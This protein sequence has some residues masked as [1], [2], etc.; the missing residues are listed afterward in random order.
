MGCCIEEDTHHKLNLSTVAGKPLPFTG[1]FKIQISINGKEMV[2]KF[3]ITDDMA[4]DALIG[5]NVIRAE[6][7]N[8]DAGSNT[9]HFSSSK[10][11]QNS[12][13]TAQVVARKQTLIQPMV[14]QL[15]KCALLQD[16]KDGNHTFIGPNTPFLATVRGV[17]L[18]ATTD[19]EGYVSLYINNPSL[20]ELQIK[21]NELL[22]NA[23]EFDQEEL[24]E[25][26]QARVAEI[27]TKASRFPELLKDNTSRTTS[28]LTAAKK[29]MIEQAV[30][31]IPNIIFRGKLRKILQ[32]N[33]QVISEDNL[34]L[35]RS[36]TVQH[37]IHL[38]STEPVYTK[39][40]HLPTNHLELVSKW[41]RDWIKI[42]IV[43]PTR[44]PYNS[45]IFCVPKPKGDGLRVVLDYR[46][47]NASTIPDRY[48]IRGVDECIQLV[49]EA[50]SR[51]FTTLDLTT[52]FWQMQLREQARH[53]TAFTLPGIG[54]FEWV[55]SPMGLTGCPASF[56]RLMD[57]TMEG[58]PNVITYIDDILVHSPTEDKHETHV[59]NTLRRL[60]QHN[61]KINLSKCIF[62]A[63]EVA[64]LGHTLTAKGV[65]PGRDK[66]KVMQECKQPNDSHTVRAFL[67]LANYFRSY[68]P[69]F[70]TLAAPLHKLT[71]K[72]TAWVNG[73]LPEDALEAFLTIRK[74]LVSEPI[75]AYPNRVGK[76][77]L[78]C[79]AASGPH[80]NKP[81]SKSTSEGGLGAC[82]MQE[83]PDINS[84]KVIG[85][86][87]R[88][89]SDSENNYS[90]F[91]LEM[92]AA[93]YGIDFY[94]HYL[95]PNTFTLYSDHK[96]LEKLNTQQ[97]RTFNLLQEKML[98]YHFDQK[99]IKGGANKVADFL[100]RMYRLEAVESELIADTR[101]FYQNF[102]K[103]EIIKL[104]AKDT[105][106]ST[107][108]REL[109]KQFGMQEF[110]PNH[111]GKLFHMYKNMLVRTLS[112]HK[113]IKNTEVSVIVAP[114][115][116]TS[117]IIQRAHDGALAGHRGVQPTLN[118][119]TEVFWWPNMDADVKTYIA[120]CKV[121]LRC[122]SKNTQAKV[123]LQQ[124]P[125]PHRPNDR[126]HVDLFGPVKATAQ[127]H[128]GSTVKKYICVMTDAFTKVVR[129]KI[130]PDKT[131]NTVAKVITEEWLNIYGVPRL[132]ITDQGL[133]FNNKVLQNIFDTWGII[134][135][136]TAPYHPQSNSQVEIFNK[137]MAQY[138]NKMLLETEQKSTEWEQFVLP[139]MF[140]YNT[141]LHSAINMSPHTAMFG[142]SAREPLWP[143]LKDLLEDDV[144][145]PGQNLLAKHARAQEF[146]RKQ[147]HTNNQQ[148]REKQLRQY[149]ARHNTS[150]PQ[151]LPGQQVLVRT[152]IQTQGNPKFEPKW[153]LAE[154]IRQKTSVTFL[155]RI[156][157]RRRK[158]TAVLNAKD[159][160]PAQKESKETEWDDSIF[161]SSPAQSSD[162]EPESGGEE[163]SE[164][165][166]SCNEDDHLPQLEEDDDPQT[167]QF[168][169][170]PENVET[171]N[172]ANDLLRFT[173]AIKANYTPDKI[174]SEP[175]VSELQRVHFPSHDVWKMVS[176]IN[177]P[178]RA[179]QESGMT[180]KR[181]I[182]LLTQGDEYGNKYYISGFTNPTLEQ[183]NVREQQPIQQP[184]PAQLPIPKRKVQPTKEQRVQR[185]M[186]RL[187]STNPPGRLELNTP[188]IVNTRIKGLRQR[189]MRKGFENIKANIVDVLSPPKLDQWSSRDTLALQRE[190]QKA[191]LDP[192][193]PGLTRNSKRMSI[194]QPT[195]NQPPAS[196][197]T[198]NPF[199]VL[200]KVPKANSKHGQS[201]GVAVKSF[202]AYSLTQ[203]SNSVNISAIASSDQTQTDKII[204]TTENSS[205]TTAKQI[206][207]GGTSKLTTATKTSIRRYKRT[208]DLAP[209]TST[210]TGLTMGPLQGLLLFTS[211]FSCVG[212]HVAA[213]TPPY[214]ASYG[215]NV[216]FEAIGVMA[217][218]LSNA[219]LS[220]DLDL[221]T[222]YHLA[223]EFLN[224]DPV[225]DLHDISDGAQTARIQQATV[226]HLQQRVAEAFHADIENQ[227][228]TAKRHR[229][230]NTWGIGDVLQRLNEQGEIHKAWECRQLNERLE[231]RKASYKPDP[232]PKTPQLSFWQQ[233]QLQN[234]LQYQGTNWNYNFQW[235]QSLEQRHNH[236]EAYLQDQ[237]TRMNNQHREDLLLQ[238][239][240]S[241]KPN[242]RRKRFV[243]PVVAV[244]AVANTLFGWHTAAQLGKLSDKVDGI[245]TATE[246]IIQ[247][248]PG[249]QTTLTNHA[250]AINAL[251]T[252]LSDTQLYINT[253]IQN[254]HR[255]SLR[256]A[257]FT[258]TTTVLRETIQVITNLRAGIMDTRILP[259]GK[260]TAGLFQLQGKLQQYGIKMLV[261]SVEQALQCP[262]SFTPTE[263]GYRVV[264]T[265]PAAQQGEMFNLYRLHQVP[266][267]L[268]DNT[269][270]T[271][272]TTEDV[273]AISP[274]KHRY[275]EMS[276][277]EL[278]SCPK[279][280]KI[281]LCATANI[282]ID[283]REVEDASEHGCAYNLYHLNKKAIRNSCTLT[284]V[285]LKTAAFQLSQTE[286]V[287]TSPSADAATLECIG[288]EGKSDTFIIPLQTITRVNLTPGCTAKVKGL[289]MT[290]ALDLKTEIPNV[291]YTQSGL[292]GKLHLPETTFNM[293]ALL[294]NAPAPLTTTMDTLKIQLPE[295]T[296]GQQPWW[297]FLVGP[298]VTIIIM[299]ATG[300]ALFCY[301]NKRASIRTTTTRG[302]Q[303]QMELE[304]LHHVQPTA[305]AYT[306]RV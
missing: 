213:H 233:T 1:V 281:A 258:E 14:A 185:E 180:I 190:R 9:F 35:G 237:G 170:Y 12:W 265:I 150:L 31:K 25:L 125:T 29:D 300:T 115:S 160:K 79:D 106:A 91:L 149:E 82:L 305:P 177:T 224:N 4:G 83:Q 39:Q 60:T 132:L 124:L 294:I 244:L 278:A 120:K 130:I 145:I 243:L 287:I 155:V 169:G 88:K 63:E 48:S 241:T 105:F 96:P 58:L 85:Y 168:H 10:P 225:P 172:F 43:Q 270:A 152:H 229:R 171:L 197:D 257:I 87:S 162:S 77:H 264:L 109:R 18:A 196:P 253:A 217:P 282:Y 159:I 195:Q 219:Y 227:T 113:I 72:N 34:D 290:A 17:P 19:G 295:R 272:T 8:Y 203:Y 288:E 277:S 221:T 11:A 211:I 260:I 256:T 22:G 104:Q 15:V 119:I 110:T 276:L 234:T 154:I 38:S 248:M 200:L 226:L 42:G 297:P 210:S 53:L 141:T 13:H 267:L 50:G 296:Q 52:G 222:P 108:I 78:F 64:Y 302:K 189:S 193:L 76:F 286:F 231:A 191:G 178:Y 176:A 81:N 49:G 54:Q 69:N 148:A 274:D 61:L 198:D 140:S 245:I 303:P 236:M 239:S 186:K 44:S 101:A 179:D 188:E 165:T 218:T 2:Q 116:M 144:V 212:R 24:F 299:A 204:L 249:I 183:K 70:A 107:K 126:I 41:V 123:P 228:T 32:T 134:H 289:T 153:T 7:L 232:N 199:R 208:R 184:T 94:D 266:L 147:A 187:Q 68:I 102:N 284:R 26:D 139:L 47:L 122:S 128:D 40:F 206:L 158:K 142:Y 5:M 238:K 71:R 133:E 301:I 16:S 65:Q 251:R 174:N 67:G 285:N 181:L 89:L 121:C 230:T 137:H 127:P 80:K 166:D 247:H 268:E 135:T 56:S 112:Q 182:Q 100:S 242:T 192:E 220:A 205:L 255:Q 291:A 201:N 173:A 261:N 214:Q 131:A 66:L 216:A 223:E 28:I 138:I 235:L 240:C 73:Q 84:M 269:Y 93:T 246:A 33:H 146:I 86:A 283:T 252:E 298:L 129:L 23:T 194:R 250:T 164:E 90:A 6:G 37:D 202:A 280:G 62:A 57:A 157:G 273:I 275:K 99:Y 262:T 74:L 118:R 75:L 98:K 292:L 59:T 20:E 156:M 51:L 55:T 27:H 163:E 207:T 97:T 46:R 271:F 143:E 111:A 209:I 304:N 114:F 175:M 161:P 151:Y 263:N 3:V 259:A 117:N 279:R 167:S 136:T 215:D 30:R 293:P 36:D 21:R 45:P 103:E 92:K 254:T 95:R 306:E